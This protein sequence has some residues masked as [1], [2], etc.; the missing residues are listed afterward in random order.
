MWN[1]EIL[2]V[3]H[4]ISQLSKGPAG[5]IGWEKFWMSQT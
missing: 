1:A 3:F 4:V 5:F 2:C